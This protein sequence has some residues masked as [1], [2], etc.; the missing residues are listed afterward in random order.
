VEA[1]LTARET[2]RRMLAFSRRE[3]ARRVRCDLSRIAAEAL[4]FL[5][6]RMRRERI[7]LRAVLADP[8]PVMEADPTQIGQAVVNL[9]VNAIQAMPRG[10]SLLVETARKGGEAVLLVADTGCG[11]SEEVKSRIFSPFFTTKG[12]SGTGLGLPVT[13]G[14]VTDHGG[15]IDVESAPGCGSRF[16]LRFPAAEGKGT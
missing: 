9:A 8:G 1:C 6:P 11:M 7:E 3:P 10:G 5:E 13:H 2:V 14:I 15:S 12:A 16:L 4:A